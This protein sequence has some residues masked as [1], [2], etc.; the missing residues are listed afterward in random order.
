VRGVA[1]RELFVL[2]SLKTSAGVVRRRLSSL[3]ELLLPIP[4][5]LYFAGCTALSEELQSPESATPMH[6]RR[7]FNV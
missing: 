5:T 7:R 6:R 3:T 4:Q 1:R 2:L